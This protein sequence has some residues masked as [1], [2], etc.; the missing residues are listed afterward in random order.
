MLLKISNIEFSYEQKI[1][2]NVSFSLNENEIIGIVGKSGIGKTTLLKII[3]GLKDADKGSVFLEDVKIVGP[4]FKLVPG[5]DDIQLVNQDFDLDIYHSVEENIRE[6]I[7]YLPLIE[8]DELVHE[9]LELLEL[10]PLRNKKALLISGGEQQRLCLARAL[11]CEPKILL[12]DEPF[13][14][15]DTRLRTKIAQYLLKLKKKRK[16]GIILVSHDGVE[17]LNLADKI[18]HFD[19]GQI[20]RMDIPFNFYFFPEN[21]KQAELF[22]IVNK[23]K[24]QGKTILFRPNEFTFETKKEIELKVDFVEY[25]FCGAYFVNHFVTEKKE[26]IQIYHTEILNETKKISIKKRN[27]AFNMV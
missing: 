19:K 7:L 16:L 15:L 25:Q 24:L 9:L 6:K 21:F 12:L 26:K 14:H 13:V 4:N 23:V 3:A 11:A 8:R 27:K 22:G 17:I 5:Y 18:I 2:D 10:M 1:I 20:K